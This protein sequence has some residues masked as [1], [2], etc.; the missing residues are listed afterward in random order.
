MSVRSFNEMN[1]KALQYTDL[2]QF[3]M[4]TDKIYRKYRD[5]INDIK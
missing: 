5:C 1:N 4:K 3:P 2:S